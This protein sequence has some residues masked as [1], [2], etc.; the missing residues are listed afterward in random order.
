MIVKV[1][2]MNVPVESHPSNEFVY[3]WNND[4]ILKIIGEDSRIETTLRTSMLAHHPDD[5]KIEK[6]ID[7]YANIAQN[8][9][10][11]VFDYFTFT[12]ALVGS[13]VGAMIIVAI[14]LTILFKKGKLPKLQAAI[15]RDKAR[16]KAISAQN[17]EDK[18][19]KKE[20]KA[21]KKEERAERRAE[22]H[23]ENNDVEDGT[24]LANGIDTATNDKE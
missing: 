24:D 3:A 15:E 18:E 7:Y 6:C 10:V 19:E 2:G 17:K 23:A 22:K 21:E 16:R 13:V 20:I 4:E 5:V 12:L 8:G 9:S 11:F 1:I 14:V